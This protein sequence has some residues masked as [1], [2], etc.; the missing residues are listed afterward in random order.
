MLLAV[1]PVTRS[2]SFLPA[3]PQF[4]YHGHFRT[5]ELPLLRRL[6][7]QAADSENKDEHEP[8]PKRMERNKVMAKM[9]LFWRYSGCKPKSV[10]MREGSRM[11]LKDAVTKR[12]PCQGSNL[13]TNGVG[14]R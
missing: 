10:Q 6:A 1:I 12:L 11:E 8:A 14:C 7:L 3:P 9:P 5:Y 4:C 2:F 13:A